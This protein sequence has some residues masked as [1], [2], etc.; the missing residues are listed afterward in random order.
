[1]VGIDATQ[2]QR[3]FQTL[4]WQRRAAWLWMAVVAYGSLFPLDWDFAAPNRFGW[5][6][7]AGKLDIVKNIALFMPLGWLVAVMARH[8]AIPD[9]GL[10]LRWTV[11]AF[12]LATLLQVAQIYLPRQPEAADVL[13]NMIGFT[14]GYAALALLRALHGQAHS[15]GRMRMS[16]PF[17][18]VLA[19][20]WVCAAMFPFVPVWRHDMLQAQFDEL[21]RFE[22]DKPRQIALH[23]GLTYLGA[24]VVHQLAQTVPRLVRYAGLAVA[25]AFLAA[26]EA[27]LLG[28]SHNAGF[29]GFV[30]MLLGL[31]AW[32]TVQTIFSAAQ[33]RVL[34]GAVAL[35]L[36]LVYA[37]LPLNARD[38]VFFQWWPFGSLL[39]GNL[40]VALRGYCTEALALGT[41][42]W[43]L[44]RQGLALK[45]AVP[46]LAVLG[47]AC[48]W[49]QRFLAFRTPEIGTVIIVLV[50]AFLLLL[51]APASRNFTSN[52]S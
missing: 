5:F 17:L 29:A 47:Y 18:L 34:L 4:L 46:S 23:A 49:V 10:A 32:L 12:L 36:Y 19:L 31:A 9:K 28:F 2:A 35:T 42:L 45:V 15:D 11:A 13:T 22:W 44:H 33:A 25:F 50:L 48:E 51:C 52:L 27:K 3:N 38:P 16:D 8:G 39:G 37:V 6:E 21:I 14:A 7:H 1:M 30:G 20:I 41:L 40:S 24:A 26:A 43:V